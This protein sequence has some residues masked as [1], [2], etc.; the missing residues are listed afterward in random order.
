M[1]Y[2][3]TGATGFIGRNLVERLLE[4][5]GD[6]YVLVREG[7]IDRLDRLTRR[8]G[9][10]DRIRPVLGD[11]TAPRLG[12]SEE[13]ITELSGA[14]AHFFHLAA[15]YDM[16]AD[17]EANRIANVEGTR[18]AVEL[19][20]TIHAGRF[21]HVSSIAA[22]GQYKGL[23]REDMFDEG[24]QLGHPY[25]RTKFESE[26]IART[27]TTVPWR[28]YRPAVV[29]GH[30]QTGEMDKIDGPYYFFTA[31]K[32]ARHYLPEWFPLVG[33]ELGYTNIVP[34][35]FVAAALDHIAHLPGL[36]GR[37]FHLAAPK[38]QRSGD[39]INT[40]ARA[41]HAPQLTLR[42][43]TRMLQALPKG[44]LSMLMALPAARGS[45][46]SASPKR[47]SAMWA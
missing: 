22:A 33:P 34:V 4:R 2:F 25:H 32:I 40:F 20:N 45:R 27:Q 35:D 5:D 39:V 17:E 26:K 1:S 15:V 19:A 37:A 21:H 16:T 14:V 42:I 46:T 8:W 7:S 12:V 28:V 31:I 47:C 29:V 13:Q 23:F 38:A 24:Q 6:V 36:D 9:A 44:T 43:D 41:A 30:S 3:V 18:H 11:L 10:G